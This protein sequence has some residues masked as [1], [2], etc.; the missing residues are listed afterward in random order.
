MKRT[1][2]H[3]VHERLG[4]RMV[5]FG[6]WHMP[7][8]YGPILDEVRCVRTAAGLFDLGHM[9]RVHVRG[10]DATLFLDRLATNHCARIPAGAIR[11]ALFCRED[12][13][14]IDD[15]L[16]YREPGEGMYLVV[17]AA[18]TAADLEWMRSHAGG[19]D[20]KIEDE[21]ERTAM[22]ALQGPRS[23]AVLQRVVTG[24]E[25]SE[26]G[27][28]RFTFATV[29]GLEG[30]RISRTGYTGEDGFEIYLPAAEGPR[31]WQALL[32]AGAADGLRP[33]GLG[34]RDILRLEA[35]MPLYGHE[36]DP[37]HDPIEAGLDFAVS[38]REEKGD[39]IGREALLAS[40]EHKT[41]R[42]VGLTSA[43]PRVPRQGAAVMLGDEAVG[44]VCSGAPS[45]TIGTNIASAYVRL[46]SDRPGTQLEIDFK[47]RRQPCTVQDLP[48]FSRKRAA[49]PAAS[50]AAS[51]RA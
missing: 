23:E 40:R 16:L 26:L 35:G 14:P 4:A 10:R 30:T 1:S 7:V 27:Y 46:G 15:L 32:E 21:T 38:F 33:I 47:G 9:G 45:P 29:A 41:R 18:N 8:Q 43:G 42:L 49:P 6:G 50:G 31:V 28:Y 39:W 48:F 13:K 34:A 17:N 36:I 37:E 22:L 5:E 44:S 11:Y 2:L 3:D 51:G 20:V 24:A 12:G 19:F 25:L